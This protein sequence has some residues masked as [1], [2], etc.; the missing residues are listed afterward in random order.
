MCHCFFLGDEEVN[1]QNV[2]NP[3]PQPHVGVHQVYISEVNCPKTWVSGDYL[4]EDALERTGDDCNRREQHVMKVVERFQRGNCHMP[5]L[6]LLSQIRVN[7]LRLLIVGGISPIADVRLF[8]L[9]VHSSW[10]GDE[11]TALC[12]MAD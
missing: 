11:D 7:E 1:S 8:L 6:H 5:C 3:H 10:K 12:C 4:L 2:L 9:L